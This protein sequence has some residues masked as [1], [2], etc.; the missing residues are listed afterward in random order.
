[1]AASNKS[2]AAHV[3]PVD[4]DFTAEEAKVEVVEAK[5]SEAPAAK[6]EP[7][8]AAVAPPPAKKRRSLALPIVALAAIAAGGWYGYDYWTYGR[9]MI[10]TDDAYVEGDITTI[11]PKV[12]GYIAKVNVVANQ[13]V[14]AGDTLVTLDNGDYRIAADQAEAQIATEKLSLNRFDAQIA[15]G[16]AS[17]QQAEAQKTALQATVRGAEISLKRA[18]DLQSKAVGTVA[19]LD[20]AQTAFDQAKANLA[21]ADASI[22]TAQ[23]NIEVLKAQRAEAESTI[24]SLE[25]TRDKAERDLGFTVIKAPYDGIVGNIAMQDG[26]LVSP[27][28]R[29]AALVPVERLYIDANF[30]ET[31]LAHMVVGSKVNIHVDA[32]D[33]EPIVG[34]VQSI[35]PAS[36]SVFSMLPPENATGNFTKVIQRVPVRI[37]FPKEALETGR[38]RAGLSVVVD[39][40]TRTAPTK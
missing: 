1:M 8:P 34:T 15:G 6:V 14:K 28:Q 5:S 40:D 33:E 20:S 12:T 23:A 30:K 31:Q 32:F 19:D 2:G 26:D 21:G 38:L 17:V 7:A 18:T 16:E 11:A 3:R 24:R 4:E 37:V 36:G 29:L 27:G 25:L 22:V 35:A 13:Q 10:S 9:F 39:V